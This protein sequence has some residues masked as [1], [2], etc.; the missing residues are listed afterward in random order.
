M[1]VKRDAQVSGGLFTVGHCYFPLRII[2]NVALNSAWKCLGM[3]FADEVN[4]T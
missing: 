4:Q 2:L 3:N 1:G